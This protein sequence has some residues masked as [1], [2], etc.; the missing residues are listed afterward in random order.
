LNLNQSR[1]LR[2][3]RRKKYGVYTTFFYPIVVVDGCLFE[4]ELDGESVEVVEQNHIQL[5][6][7]YA[8]DIFIIDVVKKEYF[9]TLLELI[10]KDHN[11]CVSA[12]NKVHFTKDFRR[13]AKEADRERLE[14]L[15]KRIPVDMFI[16]KRPSVGHASSGHR[17]RM[18]RSC[19]Q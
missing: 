8:N 10:E 9:E 18:I 7:D 12:I 17:P 15:R 4:A 1:D 16:S 5:R 2:I 13:K 3:R 19:Q 14:Y 11:Q 6:T